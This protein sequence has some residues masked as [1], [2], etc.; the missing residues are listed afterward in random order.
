MAVIKKIGLAIII[1]FFIS[2]AAAVALVIDFK[3]YAAN[4][5]PL[6]RDEITVT[7]TSGDGFNTTVSRLTTAGVIVHPTK[8]KLLARLKGDDK[9]LKAGEYVFSGSA[10]PQQVLDILV[11][12]SVKLYKLTV[13]EGYNL[14]QIA[15][16]VQAAGM[17]A[18][19]DF[20]R[21]TTNSDLTRSL[22]ID[23]DTLEGYLFPDTYFF[24]KGVSTQTVVS[25]MVKR[26]HNVFTSQ[27]QLQ[28]AGLGYSVHEVVTLAS[29]IEKE[30]GAPQERE[31]IASVFH[32]RLKKGM[33]L[34][35]DPTVIYGLKEF[36]GN[37]TRKHLNTPTAYNTYT[38]KGLPHGPIANPGKAALQAAL[39]PADTQ[40]LFFVAKRDS[41]HQFSSNL[42]DHNAAVRKYQLQK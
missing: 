24:P 31:L 1:L 7:I 28:A 25:T 32:N 2:A 41:T 34:E 5:R 35:A 37:L 42:R 3:R 33:R 23:A 18:S 14:F 26:F 21:L 4:L 13:P 38:L 8:F 30:T 15:E 12:G 22:G 27:W 19:D 40:Y 11:K 20:K 16:L 36:D 39:Y 10:S 17:G 6:G 9:R 29:I